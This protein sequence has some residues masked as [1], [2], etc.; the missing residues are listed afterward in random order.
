MLERQC[1][2][3]AGVASRDRCHME[4]MVWKRRC[5]SD[6]GDDSVGRSGFCGS[7][8]TVW[9]HTSRQ[10]SRDVCP[11]SVVANVATMCFLHRC[12]WQVIILAC[13]WKFPIKRIRRYLGSTEWHSNCAEENT[14]IVPSVWLGFDGERR[15][16]Y[17][18]FCVQEVHTLQL[19]DTPSGISHWCRR[20]ASGKLMLRLPT[21]A[22][23]VCGTTTDSCLKYA[24]ELRES[25]V[26]SCSC[27]G[28]VSGKF[29]L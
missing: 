11:C 2:D 7:L 21:T 24:R 8:C 22:P 19:N 12:K 1:C 10:S 28:S 29:S 18:L 3:A 27:T 5:G 4:P 16:E 17:V 15:S 20:K 13:L 25:S 23:S 26:K 14:I 9:V 6:V